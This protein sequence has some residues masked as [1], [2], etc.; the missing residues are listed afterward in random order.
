MNKL[1]FHRVIILTS[2]ISLLIIYGVLWVRMITDPMQY[3]GTDFVP[4]Y[5]AAQISRNDGPSQIYDLPLQ[6]KYESE[7]G[8]FDIQ[9]QDVRI[10]LNP[11]FVVPLVSLVTT[12]NFVTSLVLWEF[13]MALF[14]LVGIFLLFRSLKPHFSNQVLIIFLMGI[15]FFFP[16]YKSLV[17]GQN[18]AMLFLGACI[19]SFGLIT[20]KD[21]LAGLGL[22]LMTVRPHLALPLALP[23]IFK[24]R[25]VWWWF[26]LGTLG[27]FFFSLIYS[28]MEGVLG[29]IRILTLSASASNTTTGESNMLNLIGV[30]ARFF[31]GTPVS[32]FRW[33]GW[34]TYFMTMISLCFI[35]LKAPEIQGKHIGLALLVITFTAPHV[36]M[37]DL[38]LWAIPLTLILLSAKND[39][40]RIRF[41]ASSPW[42][43]S[44]A[45]LFSFF[46]PVLEAVIPYLILIF[47]TLALTIPDKLFSLPIFLQRGAS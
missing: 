14:L 9:L 25:G 2:S 7:L 1:N 12:P 6:Q 3:A 42:W 46:S 34:S 40:Q 32:I 26:L 23:F 35:W 4:F 39:P 41:L 13:Q 10:Y 20:R 43:L 28:G 44:I 21:W 31:P 8:D 11:P 37:H 15:L 16:G 18:S 36:H 17:I 33:I 19:W 30:L 47:L 38:I 45:F 5:A 24:R 22:A 27:L 29:F